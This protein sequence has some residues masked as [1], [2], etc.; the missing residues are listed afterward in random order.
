MKGIQPNVEESV[1]SKKDEEHSLWKST[2]FLCVFIAC[3]CIFVIPMGLSNALNTIMNTAYK[4]LIDTTLYIV[5][6]AVVAGALSALLT[7]F[8]VVQLLNRA[9]SPLMQPV[10]GMPGAAALGIVTTFLSDNPAILSLAQNKNYCKCFKAYQIPALT[11]LGTAFGMGMIVTTYMLG[12]GATSGVSLGK[13][14]L[15]GNLGAIAGGILSTRLMLHTTKKQ[16]GTDALPWDIGNSA[17]EEKEAKDGL[18]V[19]VIDALLRG[20]RSGMELG[21]SIIPG[22]LILCT[23][24]IMLTNGPS[25]T[26]AYTGAAYE[27]VGIL[28]QL[29]EKLQFILDPLFGFSSSVC[30]AVPVTAMGS[31]GATLGIAGQ[32]FALGTANAND[33]AVFTAMCICWGGYLSTHVSM[34][35]ILKCR[36]FIGTSL[37]WHTLGGIFAGAVGHWLYLFL[38]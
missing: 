24:V 29:A 11:N 30:T 28:P 6:I 22:V 34:M 25:A 5:A 12:I 31:A 2:L 13:A 33:I 7:E 35:D 18:G 37:L 4:L 9:L 36:C 27:G 23:F 38:S 14:V 8:G 19:R 26:G 1:L 32:L 17:E 16:L 15:C 3:A 10:F 21:I 20:G